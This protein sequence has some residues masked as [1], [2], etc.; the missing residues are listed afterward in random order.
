MDKMEACHIIKGMATEIIGSIAVSLCVSGSFFQLARITETRNMTSYSRIYLAS[1]LCCDFLFLIQAI[2]LRSV[3]LII[4]RVLAQ[5]Y[6]LYLCTMYV[7]TVGVV[8][9]QEID[10]S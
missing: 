10:T 4:F 8:I 7:R 6:S 5:C 3:S 9:V 1:V 2:L